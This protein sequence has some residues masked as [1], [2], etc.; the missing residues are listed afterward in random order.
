MQYYFRNLERKGQHNKYLF[1]TTND[2]IF[3]NKKSGPFPLGFTIRKFLE[4][5]DIGTPKII[6]INVPEY[7]PWLIPEINICFKLAQ[8]SKS[9]TSP[10][11]FLHH[12]LNHKHESD[13]DFFTDGSKTNIG[14][15]SGV[16]L[17][18]KKSNEFTKWNT[19]LNKLSSIFSAEL[20]A[21]YFP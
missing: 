1:N 11:E 14:V 15:G 9:N 4:E 7:P 12:Y 17:H 16:A 3:Q 10:T 21:I 8:F 18:F 5:F 6:K 20:S 2:Y 13:F 19:K